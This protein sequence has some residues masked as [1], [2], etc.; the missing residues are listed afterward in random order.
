MTRPTA[1]GSAR[2]AST[3]TPI[4]ARISTGHPIQCRA[5]DTWSGSA[6]IQSPTERRVPIDP[7]YPPDPRITWNQPCETSALT[8]GAPPSRSGR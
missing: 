2:R 5:S 7:V 6:S 4:A 3:T 8:I 1:I